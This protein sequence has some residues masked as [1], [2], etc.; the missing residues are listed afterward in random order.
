MSS[1]KKPNSQLCEECGAGCC[2]YTLLKIDKGEA[3]TIDWWKTIGAEFLCETDVGE[4]AYKRHTPCQHIGD[5]NKCKIYADRPKVCRDF[6]KED[7]PPLWRYVCK[8]WQAEH[9][10]KTLK[11]F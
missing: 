8:I 2:R 5:D 11:V 4:V 6:P 3:D 1:P 7:L 9:N 10:T